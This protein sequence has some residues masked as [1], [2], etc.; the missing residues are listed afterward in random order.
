MSEKTG[1]R[2]DLRSEVETLV[3]SDAPDEEV[4]NEIVRR[5]HDARPLWDWSGIYLLAGDT[6]VLGPRTASADHSRI[7]IGEG[8]CGTAVSEDRNQ[9][10]EDVREVENY[11]AC[12]VQTRSELV[13]L[14]RD[15]GK[16]VGEFD[17]DSD[18]VGALTHE[19]EAL[20]EEMGALISGR[21][22]SLAAAYESS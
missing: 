4:L 3:A 6:L 12:S 5:M 20:L 13:V 16:I 14:I 10:V 22:A 19:D 11:L 7:A 21:V 1:L 2:E 9:I 8:V 15:S 17:I 18:T